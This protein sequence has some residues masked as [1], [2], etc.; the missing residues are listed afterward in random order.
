V[1]PSDS[2]ASPLCDAPP[3]VARRRGQCGTRRS[4]HRPRR[5][6]ARWRGRRQNAAV[7]RGDDEERRRAHQS[8]PRRRRRRG[9]TKRRAC[10]LAG[11][12]ARAH[13]CMHRG[14]AASERAARCMRRGEAWRCDRRRRGVCSL[15]ARTGRLRA[16]SAACAASAMSY[17]APPCHVSPLRGAES[18]APRVRLSLQTARHDSAALRRFHGRSRRGG[19]AA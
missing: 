19:A 13:G 11:T 9:R 2:C 18:V 7:A 10:L 6:A 1:C 5:G 8:A 12:G 16:R 17:T 14:A 15:A 3:F 4:L